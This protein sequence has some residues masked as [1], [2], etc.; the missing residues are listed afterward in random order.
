MAYIGVSACKRDQARRS[1]I[2][3]RRSK[4]RETCAGGGLWR[5]V[6][7]CVCGVVQAVAARW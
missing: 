1:E 5:A 7:W 2:C 4:R 3:C 6:V